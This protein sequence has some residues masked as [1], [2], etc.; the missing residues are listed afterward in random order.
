LWTVALISEYA[1][2]TRI[3]RQYKA[4]DLLSDRQKQRG[5]WGEKQIEQRHKHATRVRLAPITLISEN[6]T[7]AVRE[8]EAAVKG[9]KRVNRAVFKKYSGKKFSKIALHPAL[10]ESVMLDL[11]RRAF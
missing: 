10:G 8:Q 4:T 2:A 7:E 5:L 3:E 6:T 1:S 9:K 11:A